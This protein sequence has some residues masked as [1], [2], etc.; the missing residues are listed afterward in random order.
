VRKN[1][2]LSQISIIPGVTTGDVSQSSIRAIITG[3]G[4]PVTSYVK[5]YGD[6][7]ALVFGINHLY[8]WRAMGRNEMEVE[9]NLPSRLV[10]HFQNQWH[11]ITEDGL[12]IFSDVEK[13]KVVEWLITNGYLD[14]NEDG[15]HYVQ[16]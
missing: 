3:K 15:V 5:P 2:P 14:S 11:A 6:H 1:I 4:A 7:Y 9:I 8:A 13:A 16:F 12:E 10:L